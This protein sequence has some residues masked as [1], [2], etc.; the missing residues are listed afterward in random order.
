MADEERAALIVTRRPAKEMADGTLRVQI[1]VEP[2]DRRKFLD[3]FPD[4]GDPICVVRLEKGAVMAHQQQTAFAEVATKGPHGKFAQALVQSGFFRRPEVWKAAGSDKEL[5]AWIKTQ[6]KCAA[7]RAGCEGDMVPAHVRRVAEGAGTGIKPEYC[8]VPM[9][10]KH[11]QMQHNQGEA[12]VGGK[13]HLDRAR[14]NTL[15]SWSRECIKEQLA[16]DSWTE[17][18]PPM[19]MAW[20]EERGIEPRLPAMPRT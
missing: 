2:N 8:A 11:H 19:L 9:C 7:D 16:A 10:N 6:T 3:M 14:V 18:S 1:D 15:Q 13:E 4:N 12:A 5:L 20:C 17:V